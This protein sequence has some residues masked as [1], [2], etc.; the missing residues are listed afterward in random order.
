MNCHITDLCRAVYLEIRRLRHMSR[1]IDENSLKTLASSFILSK[2]DY[3]NS[4]FKNLNKCQIE[5]L[6]KLQNFAAKTIMKKSLYDHV[7][8]C[9][10]HLHWLPIKY[11]I[12]YKIAVLTFKC[13]NGLAPDYLAELIQTYEPSRNLRSSTGNF[14]KF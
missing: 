6:Q 10:V 8:P 7:T 9:L 12:D 2:L 4:L 11:R 3:C 14:L 13:I 1:Y 5:K